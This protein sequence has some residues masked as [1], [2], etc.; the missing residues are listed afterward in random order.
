MPQERYSALRSNTR[1]L[2]K[3]EAIRVITKETE[4]TDWVSS[5]IFTE[6]RDGTLRLCLGPKD[7]NE[8]LKRTHHTT[9]TLEEITHHFS[10]ATFFGKFGAK[11]CILDNQTR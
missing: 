1:R 5:L 2:N 9:P 8:V 7:L 6:K 4:P 3:M 11:K 10:G